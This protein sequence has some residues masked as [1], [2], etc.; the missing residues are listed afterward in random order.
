MRKLIVASVAGVAILATLIWYA[1]PST[2]WATIRGANFQLIL[3]AWTMSLLTTAVRTARFSIFVPI[4]DKLL[5]AYAVFSLSR[6][7]NMSMPFRT[8][9]IA[10][11][12]ILKKARMTRTI[13]HLLP[14]WFLLR[15]SDAL[16]LAVWFCGAVIF[17]TLGREYLPVGVALIIGAT[18]ALFFM[19]H[20]LVLVPDRLLSDKDNWVVNRLA[21]VI[22][23][24]R[25]SEGVAK[26]I[27]ASLGGL[28]IW[29]F[30]IGS[31]VLT[32]IAF[33]T[34]LSLEMAFLAAVFAAAFSIIPINAPLAVGTG[35]IIWVGAMM[36]AGL[37]LETAIPLAISIRVSTVSVLI[38]EGVLGGGILL[39]LSSSSRI[40]DT[41]K[42]DIAK[43]EVR[44]VTC[45]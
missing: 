15:V 1:S 2:I 33:D 44:S 21:A 41:E 16:A 45:E 34:P 30:L 8:G 20:A 37:P 29:G 43:D 27:M 26:R 10:M 4:G 24:V 17:S 36:I 32:Q 39:G 31:A 12:A 40:G 23:G 28:L 9:D 7:V 5:R 11:L 13:A 14:I 18:C 6:F 35:E 22:E 3:A 38:I 19:Q 42:L 25:E